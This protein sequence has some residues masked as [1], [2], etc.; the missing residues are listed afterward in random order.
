MD[1]STILKLSHIVATVLGVGG[2]TF[3]EIFSIK[4]GRQEKIDQSQLDL[5]RI[6][7]TVIR[8]GAILLVLSGFGYLILFRLTGKTD[9]L[10]NPRLW[11]KLI[12]TLVILVNAVA[13]TAK[14]I[15]L[16]LGAGISLTSWYAALVLG[17]WRGLHG[18]LGQ[19]LFGYL[20]AIL[21]VTAALAVVKRIL[22]VKQ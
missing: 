2:A 17:G 1:W 13:L 9:L 3:A 8:L 10:Y 14:K 15:P 11:A 22:G 21:V 16:Y 19:I 4:L 18:S 7:Y 12:I 6:V 20:V 5:M